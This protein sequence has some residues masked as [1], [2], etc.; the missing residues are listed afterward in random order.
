MITEQIVRQMHPLLI[1]SARK[2]LPDQDAEDVVQR[3]WLSAMRASESFENRSSI[4]TWLHSI[5]RRR[6]C[7]H[8]RARRRFETLD[9]VL[10]EGPEPSLP[11]LG[12]LRAA[13]EKATRSI[14]DLKGA[15]RLAI[16][17]VD[18]A[19]VNRDDVALR[20]G[21]TRGH[22][23]VVLFRGREKVARRLVRQG[24]RPASLGIGSVRGREPSVRAALESRV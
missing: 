15:E 21:V 12:D 5:L 17:L 10:D 14:A 2:V 22:L 8:L 4:G 6:I 11:D 1:R 3:T 7:D 20:L 19:G 9:D 23:R 24:V 18:I 16:E 13:A